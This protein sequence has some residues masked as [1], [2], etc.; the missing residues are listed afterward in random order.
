M[1]L[2]TS[3]A[4]ALGV[5]FL[6]ATTLPSQSSSVSVFTGVRLIDGTERP[7]IDNA[8][9]VVRDG[10][11]VSAGSNVD[12]PAGARAVPLAGKTVIPGLI[13]AH[14]HVGD[15]EG[16]QGGRYSAGHVMRDLRLY[17]AYGVT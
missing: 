4:L 9:L 15:T 11:V 7:P 6:T 5:V 17:A 13:N 10:R 1:R 16:L 8:T 2:A 3:S 14:G 12:V